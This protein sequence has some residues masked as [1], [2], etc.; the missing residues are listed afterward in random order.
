MKPKECPFCGG[1]AVTWNP[2][3]ADVDYA[4]CGMAQQMGEEK[5]PGKSINVE[6]YRWNERKTIDLLHPLLAA[7]HKDGGDYTNAYG[8]TNSI[9][10]ATCK[11][12]GLIVP[13][14]K[15]S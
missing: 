1:P 13:E 10:D 6:V 11:V 2:R 9:N 8:L 5:C 15:S 12:L 3:E 4:T 14:R 7:I